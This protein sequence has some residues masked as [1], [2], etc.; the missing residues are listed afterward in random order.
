MKF[1]V[2][3]TVNL[4]IVSKYNKCNVRCNLLNI[5]IRYVYVFK[6]NKYFSESTQLKPGGAVHKNHK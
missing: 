2:K 6:K 3:Y 4:Y 1:I 5:M